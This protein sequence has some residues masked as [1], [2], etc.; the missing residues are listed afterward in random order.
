MLPG[1]HYCFCPFGEA[2]LVAARADGDLEHLVVVLLR[3]IKVPDEAAVTLELAQIV[4]RRHVAA[5]VPAFVADAK[6]GNLVRSGMTVGGA[7]LLQRSW[8]SRSQ[9]FQ[10]FCRFLHST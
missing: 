5:T 9:I 4:V 3:R 8:L 10:P 7:F 6:K 2:L 1:L